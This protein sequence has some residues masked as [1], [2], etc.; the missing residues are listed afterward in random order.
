MMV[1]RRHPEDALAGH[2]E[3]RDLDDHRDGLEHEQPAEDDIIARLALLAMGMEGDA[4]LVH[5]QL[6]NQLLSAEVGASG[7]PV[8]GRNVEDLIA[9]VDGDT[10]SDRMLDAMLRTGPHGDAFGANPDGLSLQK[11]RNTFKMAEEDGE[12]RPKLGHFVFQGG[13]GTGKSHVATALGVQAIEHHRKR[14]R[15]FSTVELVNALEQAGKDGPL[16]S[17]MRANLRAAR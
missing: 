1:Q 12:N 14:V 10:G 7:S 4:T 8:E 2:L 6:V 11:L 5:D 9:M 13:P 3:R 17:Q 15:F 16:L